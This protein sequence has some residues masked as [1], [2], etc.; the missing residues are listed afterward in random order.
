MAEF[1]KRARD[2]VKEIVN[3]EPENLPAYNVGATCDALGCKR[4]ENCR[5]CLHS[6]SRPSCATQEELVRLALGEVKEHAAQAQQL[7]L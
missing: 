6:G 2:L 5:S 1:A 7:L 3:Y 4:F